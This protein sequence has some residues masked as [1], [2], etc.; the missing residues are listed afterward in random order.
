MRSQT[1]RRNSESTAMPVVPFFV[2]DGE[3][4]PA[5]ITLEKACEVI[6]GNKPIHESTYYRGAKKGIYPK[7]ERAPGTNISRVNTQKLLQSPGLHKD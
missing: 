6:G 5:K 2:V 1:W 4:L 3:K 7:P